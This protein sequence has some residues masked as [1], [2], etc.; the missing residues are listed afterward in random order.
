MSQQADFQARFEQAR[1][2]HRGGQLQ[3]AESLYLQLAQPGAYQREQVL[4]ALVELYLQARQ[5]AALVE[6]MT[7][8]TEEAPDNFGYFT[9]L[10]TL[11]DRLGY[12]EAAVEVYERFLQAHPDAAT[13][14][15][16][17]ALVL[18]RALRHGD[19]EAAYHKAIDLGI[20]GLPEVYSNIGVLY[21]EMRR[22][23]AARE[24]YQ[25][26]LELQ[27]D[28]LPALF[29]LAGS[30][31]ESGQRGE[32]VRFYE[33]LLEHEPQHAEALSRLAYAATDEQ[34]AALVQRIEAALAE[35]ADDSAAG[36][37]LYFALG[38]LHDQ[39]GDYAAAATAYDRANAA[40]SKRHPPYRRDAVQRSF[41]ELMQLY[42]A[43]WIAAHSSDSS[44]QPV[45]I[46][47]MHR[48]GSTLVERMLGQHPALTAG[49][50]LDFMP[51]LISHRLA[52]Y[53][54]RMRKVSNEDL[55]QLGEEY[56]QRI[57]SWF[58][59]AQRVTDKRPDNFLH[60]G[61][62]RA[63]YPQAKIIYTRRDRVDNCLSIYFQQLGGNLDYATD[64]GNTAHYFTL[65]EQ[66]MQ[67]WQRI[68][69]NNIHTVDYDQLVREPESEL[70]ALL[71]FLDL[72]WDPACLD[73][74]AT[75][76][77]VATASL[78]QVRGELHAG[79]SGRWRNYLAA[80]PQLADLFDLDP[81]PDSNGS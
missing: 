53:P 81:P 75:D 28:F 37:Y 45:F 56:L 1:Q 54:E 32:A 17:Y 36:E 25:R 38:K 66:L 14:H 15:F 23:A 65:H 43:D 47:G 21:A 46:C 69:G 58:P 5:P 61:L 52:P 70:R 74:S 41:D 2:L 80:W 24:H 10:A 68:P 6:A 67:Y 62:I 8:L 79:S 4:L 13:A 40:G 76:A 9:Q 31:E 73:F 39:S 78:W 20:D 50:E 64:L 16:N 11:L 48:S 29:N 77:Q 44:A 51:W 42:T 55:H 7:A 35:L 22:P 12:T 27:P 19:A 18:K 30:Y 26:A 60:L 59:D 34:V 3:Q 71:T 72:P 49:G 63:V 57:H 33:Q